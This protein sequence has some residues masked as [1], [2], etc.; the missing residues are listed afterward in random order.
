MINE[1]KPPKEIITVCYE[2]VTG[3]HVGPG[4]LALFFMGNED[5]REKWTYSK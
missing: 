5:Y 4:A 1:S 3:S 2:P